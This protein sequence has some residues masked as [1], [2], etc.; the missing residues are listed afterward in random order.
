[1]LRHLWM[2]PY[3]KAPAAA[4]AGGSDRPTMT[5]SLRVPASRPLR[6]PNVS[7]MLGLHQSRQSA[8]ILHWLDCYTLSVWHQRNS[9]RVARGWGGTVSSVLWTTDRDITPTTATTTMTSD[10]SPSPWPTIRK[11][12]A[13]L[14]RFWLRIGIGILLELKTKV[15]ERTH[16][17]Q[18]GNSGGDTN[19]AFW[20][21][22]WL[23]AHW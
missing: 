11:I 22:M 12:S 21:S 2:V 20:R 3:Y 5:T 19:N 9:S 10:S 16:C 18:L 4:V 15:Q 17:C 13:L 6:H 14:I 23:E 7:P 1:M 8:I